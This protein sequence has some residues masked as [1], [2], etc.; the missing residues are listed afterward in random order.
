MW[1]KR[2][3][4]HKVMDEPTSITKSFIGKVHHLGLEE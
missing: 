3:H 2:K 1:K 4:K